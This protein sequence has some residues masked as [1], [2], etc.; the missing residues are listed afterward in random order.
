[1]RYLALSEQGFETAQLNA[2]YLSQ[3]AHMDRIINSLL[4]ENNNPLGFL[5]LGDFYYY[6]QTNYKMA[7]NYY[8]AS[9]KLSNA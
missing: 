9:E 3:Q 6:N 4:A 5:R 1:M 7:F 2:E 8:K